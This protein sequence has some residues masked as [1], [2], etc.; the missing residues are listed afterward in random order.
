MPFFELL[1]LG[2]LL[3]GLLTVAGL[4]WMFKKA[5][6]LSMTIVQPTQGPVLA[7]LPTSQATKEPN[8]E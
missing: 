8:G 3:F 7:K 2:W 4:S 5:V 1:V 6:E